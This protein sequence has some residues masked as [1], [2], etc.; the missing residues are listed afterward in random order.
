MR[1]ERAATIAWVGAVALSLSLGLSGSPAAG[2]T[3]II[4]T[5]PPCV[6]SPTNPGFVLD[7]ES[8]Q[9]P[10]GVGV[11]TNA[12]VMLD[13]PVSG[14]SYDLGIFP[15]FAPGLEGQ[16]ATQHYAWCNNI[17]MG[18]N[19]ELVATFRQQVDSTD[20]G[21]DAPP[22]EDE[23]QVGEMPLPAQPIV[24]RCRWSLSPAS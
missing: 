18:I 10:L 8:K 23:A 16:V 6:F 3:V 9:Y 20:P 4:S 14:T 24:C 21:S 19:G 17:T 22:G 13:A 7:A 1:T 12:V 11:S 2:G 15:N 5:E